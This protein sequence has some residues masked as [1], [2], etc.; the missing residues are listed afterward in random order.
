MR[1]CKTKHEVK[2]NEI[3]IEDLCKAVIYWCTVKV[4]EYNYLPQ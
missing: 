1:L 3:Y 2:E 4:S